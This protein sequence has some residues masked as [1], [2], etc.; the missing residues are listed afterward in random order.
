MAAG[1]RYALDLTLTLTPPLT[2]TLTSLH[3]F[4][5]LFVLYTG[6]GMWRRVSGRLTRIRPQW[7]YV[8][9]VLR[10]RGLGRDERELVW[11]HI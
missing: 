11:G 7:A 9:W 1:S 6:T 5:E 8:M 4:G 10:E 3:A 2:L